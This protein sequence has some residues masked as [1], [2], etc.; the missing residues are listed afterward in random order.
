MKKPS[1]FLIQKCEPSLV[2]AGIEEAS[3]AAAQPGRFPQLNSFDRIRLRAA[4]NLAALAFLRCLTDNRVPHQFST[5]PGFSDSAGYFP[6]IGGRTCIP[7]AQLISRRSLIRSLR[8][9]PE[10]IIQREVYLPERTE[11]DVFG[12]EDLYVFAFTSALVTRS[13]EAIKQAVNAREPLHLLYRMPAEWSLPELWS[14]LE[15]LVLK[16]DLSESV[17]LTLHGQDGHQQYCEQQVWLE[18]RKRTAVSSELFSIGALGIDRLPKGPVGIHNPASGETLLAGPYQWGNVWLYGIE[19]V[20]AGYI[21]R[22]DFHRQAVRP[23]ISEAL[24]ANPCLADERLLSLPVEGL[25]SLP[26]LFQRAAAWA[27]KSGL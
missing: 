7:V 13:R 6:V 16:T 18:G 10:Q 8:K 15:R 24:Y 14:P 23:A 21:R 20:F 4:D 3:R 9:Q 26:D 22:G 19:I 11:W 17:T 27:E 5:S 12:E 2:Q 25:K 1:D